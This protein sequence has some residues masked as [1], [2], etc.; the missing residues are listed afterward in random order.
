MR[1]D[2]ERN[3]FAALHKALLAPLEPANIVDKSSNTKKSL[4]GQAKFLVFFCNK[5]WL[6]FDYHIDS[7][8]LAGKSIT[9]D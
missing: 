1:S 2:T 5:I 8:C 6:R 3:H 7:G 9:N 4:T